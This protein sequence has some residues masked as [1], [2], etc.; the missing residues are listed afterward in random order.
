M[1]ARHIKV[2]LQVKTSTLHT[3]VDQILCFI[4]SLHW[5]YLPVVHFCCK[6]QGILCLDKEHSHLEIC[7]KLNREVNCFE[8]Y[9]CL[10]HDNCIG[11][12]F[13]KRKASCKLVMKN[14]DIQETIYV[15]ANQESEC[16]MQQGTCG[17]CNITSND[18]SFGC[19]VICTDIYYRPQTKF[20]AR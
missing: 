1:V 17:L 15:S 8:F 14:D 7:I 20:G 18:G 9:R 6:L 4:T 11:Y 5:K 19:P 16:L 13:F 3:F 2:K 12:C 10:I